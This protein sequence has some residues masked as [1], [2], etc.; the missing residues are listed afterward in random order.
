V[1]VRAGESDV[2]DRPDRGRAVPG[3]VL[4]VDP[5]I[6]DADPRVEAEHVGK[7]SKHIGRGRKILILQVF[8]A[9]LRCVAIDSRTQ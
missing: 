9:K 7:P 5:H 1:T 4:A 8:L 2:I 6:A 3:G